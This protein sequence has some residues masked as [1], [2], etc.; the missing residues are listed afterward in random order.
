MQMNANFCCSDGERDYFPKWEVILKRLFRYS[1]TAQLQQINLTIRTMP[2][3]KDAPSLMGRAC[4]QVTR[5]DK[6]DKGG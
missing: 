3:L 1:L 4:E 6:G 5:H 2:F